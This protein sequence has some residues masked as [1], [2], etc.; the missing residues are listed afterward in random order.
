MRT[1]LD[2][3]ASL[4]S[5]PSTGAPLT[6]F[7][8]EVARAVGADAVALLRLL[9]DVLFPV[10]TY[11]LAPDCMGRSFPLAEHPRLAHGM[12][13]GEPSVRTDDDPDPFDGLLERDPGAELPIHACVV[14]PLIVG[15]RPVGA[16]TLDALDPE[17]LDSLDEASLSLVTSLAAMALETH[18]LRQSLN[19]CFERPP[20]LI[21]AA[22]DQP[23]ESGRLHGNGPAMQR[24]RAEIELVARSDYT[25]IV[26][27]ETGVGKELVCRSLHRKSKRAA[28]P[29]V[30]VNCAALPLHLA[31]SELFGHV[32]G[33]FTGAEVDRRGKFELAHGG[34]L[35]LDEICELPLLVQPKLLR[36]LQSGEIQRV[37]SDEMH[38]VDVRVIAATNRDVEKEVEEGR[39]RAD[40]FHRLTEYRI[41]VPPLRERREDVPV[42]MGLFAERHQRRLG[43]GPVRFAESARELL[44][45]LE[46]KGNV[47]E[48]DHTLG[49]AILRSSARSTPRAPVVVDAT[50]CRPG[51]PLTTEDT[52]S[53]ASFR[54]L[55]EAVEEFKR[56]QIRR[57]VSAHD[58]NWAAA[59]R[60]LGMHRSN[61]HHLAERLGLRGG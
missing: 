6:E 21:E 15:G 9:D 7:V 29:L 43:I 18:D 37:G 22:S 47:R 11:G 40:L 50:D 49:Q 41:F 4:A 33:A 38:E 52:G 35:F 25:V 45:S 16:L 55:R 17:A 20:T 58:G 1:L 32:R 23:L 30:Y 10:A 57:A 26:T 2:L 13:D 19:R 61:L 42:L 31:E 60:A 8:R 14:C 56:D 59:A 3:T 5:A 48:L 12:S 53:P 44:T 46:W 24:V 28:G 27:G 51:S 54:P 39:F 34:T 36:A